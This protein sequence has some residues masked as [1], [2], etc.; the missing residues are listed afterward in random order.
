M[1]KPVV[2]I[3]QDAGE[4]MSWNVLQ[5]EVEK[6]GWQLFNLS[7]TRGFLPRTLPIVGG[8]VQHGAD[9]PLLKTLKEKKIPFVRIGNAPT[10]YYEKTFSDRGFGFVVVQRWY[11]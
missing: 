11:C 7:S 2:L 5:K 10:F 1:Q 9:S 4:F 8:L 3:E 6:Y